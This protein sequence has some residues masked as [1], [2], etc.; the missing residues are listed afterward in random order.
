MKYLTRSLLLAPL[1]LS[2]ALAPSRATAQDPQTPEPEAA[3]AP[4]SQTE[5]ETETEAE[6][7]AA[8]EPLTRKQRKQLTEALAPEYQR[9]L[10]APG[11]R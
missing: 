4:G 2:L 9:W 3:A 7:I 11:V 10:D 6:P 1:V 5:A 8:G